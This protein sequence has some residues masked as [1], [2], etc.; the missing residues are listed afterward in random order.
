MSGYKL[1]LVPP[2]LG[3]DTGTD[4]YDCTGGS[5]PYI[6]K[7]DRIHGEWSCS[8]PDFQHRKR[9]GRGACKHIAAAIRELRLEPQGQG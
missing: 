9:R 1:E 7:H 3:Y 8:C 6:L 5:E 4:I 2:P